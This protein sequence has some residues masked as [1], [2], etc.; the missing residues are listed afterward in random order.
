MACIFCRI[1]AGEIPA[2]V[3]LREPDVVAFLDIQ[4]LADGHVVVVPRA[5]VAL[6]EELEPA[7]AEALFRAVVRLARPVRE[8]LGA[9]GTTIGVNNGEAT[10]QTIPHVHVHIV[11]RREGDGAGS[12]HTIFPRGARRPLGEVGEA[13][14]RAAGGLT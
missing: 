13:I 14:R 1:V 12:V 7:A 5:H 10:G 3:V 8:A 2:E 9:A 11:P 6:L 4:P